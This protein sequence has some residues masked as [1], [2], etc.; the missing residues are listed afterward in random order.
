VQG[1]HLYG[2]RACENNG[3]L[4]KINYL[5]IHLTDTGAFTFP[6]TKY[7]E[8]AAK[9][10][11]KYTVSGMFAAAVRPSSPQRCLHGFWSLIRTRTCG[12]VPLV[13]NK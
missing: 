3:R 5:H 12:A 9:S 7:P 1:P 10:A 2:G 11:F 4:Y 6:S 13:G 8:L